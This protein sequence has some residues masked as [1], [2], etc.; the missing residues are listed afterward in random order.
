MEDTTI[1]LNFNTLIEFSHKHTKTADNLH[2]ATTCKEFIEIINK[3]NL[4][5]FVFMSNDET[6]NIKSGLYVIKKVMKIIIKCDFY[7]LQVLDVNN[8][9]GFGCLKTIRFNTANC[10]KNIS[11]RI[12]PILK[13]EWCYYKLYGV[14]DK[15]P[16]S[17]EPSTDFLT[18]HLKPLPLDM[19]IHLSVS[20]HTRNTPD[21]DNI[22]SIRKF[23][24][25]IKQQHTTT[26]LLMSALM[27]KLDIDE[28]ETF[29]SHNIFRILKSCN[30]NRLSNY[31]MEHRRSFKERFPNIN[32]DIDDDKIWSFREK[33]AE[34]NAKYV[35]KD[36][37]EIFDSFINIMLFKN[38]MNVCLIIDTIIEC[39]ELDKYYILYQ[40][41]ERIK[42][43]ADMYYSK[44]F[45]LI[46]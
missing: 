1:D 27:C 20:Y 19:D 5:Y 4:P 8:N 32:I 40:I 39:L 34:Y 38:N 9:V 25:K 22:Q 17:F 2:L 23:S 12:A 15:I 30:S 36:E 24:D 6:V 26:S 3:M 33:T 7:P 21:Y 46:K 37:K 29:R 44:V 14:Y 28:Y 45:Q 31:P 11:F 41:F 13:L 43:F 42:N 35:K 16:N 10:E 18:K